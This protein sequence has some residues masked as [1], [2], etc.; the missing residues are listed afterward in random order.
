MKKLL[1]LALLASCTSKPT[2][3]ATQ[4]KIIKLAQHLEPDSARYVP[5][6]FSNPTPFT[7]GDSVQPA[8]EQYKHFAE[9]A[10]ESMMLT[11]K[12][13]DLGM[14]LH[15]PA[16]ELARRDNESE[17]AKA[18]YTKLM[19]TQIR[20]VSL[21]TDKVVGQEIRHS[22]RVGDRVDSAHFVVFNSGVVKRL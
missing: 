17:K 4:E 11:A 22:W 5:L 20:L 18:E 19:Q 12:S 15:L 3:T 1:L 13:A 6:R 9:G 16:S 14:S 7:R 8:I 2:Y 21:G 10:R